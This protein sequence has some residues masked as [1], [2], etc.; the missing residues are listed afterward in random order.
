[1][2]H[3]MCLVTFLLSSCCLR[4]LLIGARITSAQCVVFLVFGN[5]STRRRT[6]GVQWEILSARLV[7]PEMTEEV[8]GT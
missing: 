3:G 6:L 1:M 8:S 7:L 2:R 4:L 5:L